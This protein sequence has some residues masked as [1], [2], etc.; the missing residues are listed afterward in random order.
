MRKGLL[1]VLMMG[2][3]FL[4]ACSG[5]GSV[6]PEEELALTIR[7]EYAA[8]STWT[9]QAEIT[10]DYGQRVY[11][12]AVAAEFD[13][14]QTRLTL[15]APDTVAGLTAVL[16]ENSGALE[17]DGLWVETGPL[18]PEGLT[19]AAAL[20]ALVE[21]A[22]TGYIT[23]CRLEEDGLLRVDCGDPE[24]DPGVGTET[25]LWFQPDSHQLLRGEISR[26]GFR[27]IRCDFSDFSKT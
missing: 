9:A 23:A 27:A 10:A 14:A 19:P 20:S 25:A 24:S 6:S 21:T 11:E 5:A 1:C 15:T 22:R 18:D 7:G 26:E 12:Y 8:L 3:L 4:P 13:G 2:L 17:F 16:T